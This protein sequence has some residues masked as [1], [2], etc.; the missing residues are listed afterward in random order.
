MTRKKKS[1][2]KRKKSSG[3]SGDEHSKKAAKPCSSPEGKLFNVSDVLSQTNSVLYDTETALNL[4]TSY[5]SVF[6]SPVK[7]ETPEVMSDPAVKQPS[8][9][10]NGQ[11]TQPILP[12]N[13]D[14]MSFLT[15]LDERITVMDSKLQKLE[16]VEKKIDSFDSE[17]KKLWLHIDK[18]NKTTSDRLLKTEEKLETT[19]FAVGVASDQ[20]TRLEEENVKLKD[21][22]S[23]LQSQSM[24]N[25]LI[26]GGIS[27]SRFEKNEE[28]EAK[29]RSF[30]HEK[31]Q[32]ANDVVENLKFERV[33]RIGESLPDKT[34][35]I[36]C[37]FNMF[38]EREMVR[39]QRVNLEG[40]LLA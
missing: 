26:F 34:R 27:E 3:S 12:T 11:A 13:A 28:T 21:T 25:N 18:I 17:L 8:G 4:N 32:I 22:M 20:I 37:K 35:K 36:V 19:E 24:R 10:V 39:R 1:H 14:L 38:P 40:I 15:K 2:N 6:S 9:S 29:L 7:A 31:L 30:M 5:S 16:V 23:Y 33:H